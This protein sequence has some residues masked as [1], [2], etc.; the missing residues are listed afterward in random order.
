V[1][2]EVEQLFRQAE[3]L[4]SAISQLEQRARWVA[5][6]F[7]EHCNAE[8][9]QRAYKAY[10]GTLC[11]RA[12][13]DFAAALARVTESMRLAAVDSESFAREA[14]ARVAEIEQALNAG[15]LSR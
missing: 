14:N 12:L 7:V 10:L 9:I 13:Q 15:P 4:P 1:L 5:T 11:D 2:P 3:E 6:E 8:N